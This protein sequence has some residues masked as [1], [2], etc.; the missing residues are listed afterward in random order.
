MNKGYSIEEKKEGSKYVLWWRNMHIEYFKTL[1]EL[2]KRLQPEGLEN[3][4]E[5]F[6]LRK[7]IKVGG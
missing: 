1:E 5:L 6:P 7:V 4:M 3:Q 2:N